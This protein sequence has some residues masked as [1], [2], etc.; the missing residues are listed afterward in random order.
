MLVPASFSTFLCRQNRRVELCHVSPPNSLDQLREQA[1]LQHFL[2]AG[3]PYET[4]WRAIRLPPQR[5]A[6]SSLARHPKKRH[7]PA[8]L[9]DWPAVGAAGR[10]RAG[11]RGCLAGSASQGCVPVPEERRAAFHLQYRQVLAHRADAKLGRLRL[12]DLRHTAASHAVML[13]ETLPL[14][15]KLL[16]HRR[17]ETTAGYAHLEDG[18]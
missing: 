14:V 3:Q 1:R 15:G 9:Q 5:S 8:R 4:V 2:S 12:H 6:Q 17:H 10:V 11:H 13:G 16:G 18:T 7:S